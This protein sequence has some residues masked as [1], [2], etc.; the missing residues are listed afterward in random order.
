MP[1]LAGT[2]HV[3]LRASISQFAEVSV[4]QIPDKFGLPS[5]VLGTS[6]L[7]AAD[8]GCCCAVDTDTNRKSATAWMI[9]GTT[10]RFT[11]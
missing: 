7:A 5:A 1:T 3:A 6:R 11:I 9:D 10:S 4:C 2:P 8:W